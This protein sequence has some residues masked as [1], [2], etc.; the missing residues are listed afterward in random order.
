MSPDYFGP[1][2]ICIA[3]TE[4]NSRYCCYFNKASYNFTKQYNVFST[5]DEYATWNVSVLLPHVDAFDCVFQNHVRCNH[6][7]IWWL[8]RGGIAPTK[9]GLNT[10]LSTQQKSQIPLSQCSISGLLNFLK[11]FQIPPC[12][13]GA[14]VFALLYKWA[15]RFT[16][17]NNKTFKKN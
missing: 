9:K 7:S 6:K 12:F 2:T 5:H 11:I 13:R 15:C 17:W 4:N 14:G 1:K 16:A 10:T 3:I 8:Y